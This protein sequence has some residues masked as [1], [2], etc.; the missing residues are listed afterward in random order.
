MEPGSVKPKQDDHAVEADDNYL[1]SQVITP[2]TGELRKG[3]VLTSKLGR[4]GKPTGIRKK[5]ILHNIQYE[6]ILPDG[7]V[8]TY[9]ANTISDKLYSNVDSEGHEI[10]YL[11]EILDHSSDGS[12]IYKDE[13]HTTSNGRKIPENTTIGWKI[14][15]KWKDSST[16][17][18]LLKNIK[19]S[20]PVQ[21]VEYIVANKISTEPVFHQWVRHV[22]RKRDKIIKK[23]KHGYLRKIH[24]YGIEA[25]TDISSDIQLNTETNNSVWMDT[26]E[27]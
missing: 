9:T 5:H 7:E 17:W 12:V 4:N 2:L 23:V 1:N 24:N 16:S 20:Y 14:L 11:A 25:P 10:L 19:E 13:S 21:V 15:C 22:L 27:K 26:I 8:N 6:V 3:K 18:V